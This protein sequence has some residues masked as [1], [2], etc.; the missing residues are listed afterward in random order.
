MNPFEQT[1]RG[2]ALGVIWGSFP[3]G[4]AAPGAA[5]IPLSY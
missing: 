3:I 1:A 4:A 5:K 2:K